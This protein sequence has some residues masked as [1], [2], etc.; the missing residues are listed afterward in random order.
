MLTE[1]QLAEP[2]VQSETKSEK[3]PKNKDPKRV[4]AG[5]KS[6]EARKTRAAEQQATAEQL[7]KLLAAKDKMVDEQHETPI[8]VT[9][10]PPAAPVRDWAPWVVGGL[11]LTAIAWHAAKTQVKKQP[12]QQPPAAQKSQ[13]KIKDPFFME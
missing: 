8:T 5:L 6:A 3:M 9:Q 4:V 12:A 2:T 1:D 7:A 13:P 10:E 11:G